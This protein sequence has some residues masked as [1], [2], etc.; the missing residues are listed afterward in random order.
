MYDRH[1]TCN[2]VISTLHR[3]SFATRDCRISDIAV[4]S[5]SIADAYSPAAASDTAR[6]IALHETVRFR[7]IISS[8]SASDL[9]GSHRRRDAEEDR[10]QWRSRIRHKTRIELK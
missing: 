3:S 5:V 10:C 7:F 2:D 9:R 4:T 8:I 1:L 6:V